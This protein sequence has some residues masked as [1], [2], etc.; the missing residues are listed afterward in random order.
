MAK[1]TNG[2]WRQLQY[3]IAA[4]LFYRYHPCLRSASLFLGVGGRWLELLGRRVL[5][6]VFENVSLEP[7]PGSE[8]GLAA[9]TA[10]GPFPGV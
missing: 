1:L 3:H 8:G 7:V 2:R 10:V 5:R 9:L 4:A 6:V